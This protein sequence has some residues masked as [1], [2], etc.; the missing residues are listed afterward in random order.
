MTVRC[1]V[2]PPGGEGAG[3][4]PSGAL[5]PPPTESPAPSIMI[6]APALPFAACI[7]AAAGGLFSQPVAKEG[8]LD[9]IHVPRHEVGGEGLIGEVAAHLADWETRDIGVG[10]PGSYRCFPG[11]WC[12]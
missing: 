11:R 8:V 6:D 5:L 9:V 7:H 3:S 4:A 1:P 12:R 2:W 10:P